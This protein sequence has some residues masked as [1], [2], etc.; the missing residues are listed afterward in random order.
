MSG[1]GE[2]LGERDNYADYLRSRRE[3][4]VRRCEGLTPEQLALR[5]VPPSTMSLL[6]MVRHLAEVERGWGPRGRDDDWNGAVGEQAAVDEA[7]AAWREEVAFG[8]DWLAGHD[9]MAAAVDG[10]HHGQLNVRDVVVHL[11]EE[12]AQHLGH[13]DLLRECIDGRTGL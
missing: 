12:Y 10:G 6:G 7:W 5:S 4:F 9:D 11:I 8:E 1:M 3:G 2:L 13:A